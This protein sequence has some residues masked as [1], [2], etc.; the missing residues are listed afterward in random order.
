MPS[1]AAAARPAC[2]AKGPSRTS[3][4]ERRATTSSF[5]WV[6]VGAPVDQR[7]TNC[8]GAGST[9]QGY[10]IGS[11]LARLG[12]MKIADANPLRTKLRAKKLESPALNKV[13]GGRGTCCGVYVHCDVC[14][15]VGYLSWCGMFAY[16]ALC[17]TP[18]D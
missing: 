15:Y 6:D 5:I 8:S 4:K 12:V 10:A 11:R 13:G 16:C 17:G 9:I 14:G 1:S 7:C 2:C 3:V 18:A